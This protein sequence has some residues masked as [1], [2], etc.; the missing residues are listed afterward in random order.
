M[1]NR[2]ELDVVKQRT[3]RALRRVG[4]DL[5]RLTQGDGLSDSD[6]ATMRSVQTYTMTSSERI[7]ALCDAV[8]YLVRNNIGGDIVE[9]GVWRG[10]SMMA[11]ARTLLAEGDTGRDLYLYDTYT[12]MT[13]PTEAD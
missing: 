10:G 9:C 11:I 2:M 3:Q 1:R 6:R 4:V 5:T 12:G 13:E 8:R 7:A